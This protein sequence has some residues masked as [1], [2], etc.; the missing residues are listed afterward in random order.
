[1]LHDM[2]NNFSI[3]VAKIEQL[4]WACKQINQILKLGKLGKFSSLASWEHHNLSTWKCCVPRKSIQLHRYWYSIYTSCLCN[5][6]IC[7]IRKTSSL[8]DVVLF[9]ILN[10][11]VS[12]LVHKKVRWY[13]STMYLSITMVHCIKLMIARS[14]GD[15]KQ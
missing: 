10:I 9:T 1:M 5:V 15:T 2:L 4:Y 8:K 12:A 7:T 6:C 11:P 3:E 14:K 13:L